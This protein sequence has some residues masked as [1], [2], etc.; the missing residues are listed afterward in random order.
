MNN[1]EI[2]MKNCKK[3]QKNKIV[4]DTKMVQNAD[5]TKKNFFKYTN[6]VIHRVKGS[7]LPS[8]EFF[9]YFLHSQIF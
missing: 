5:K 1:I 7:N 6:F 3:K 4:T 2:N 9:F 8:D